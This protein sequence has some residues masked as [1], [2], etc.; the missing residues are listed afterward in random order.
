MR[1]LLRSKLAAYTPATLTP[2]AVRDWPDERLRTACGATVNRQLNLL[3][4]VIEHARKEWGIGSGNP[5]SNVKRPK[6]NRAR[7]R[8]LHQGEEG[9]LLATCES[10]SSLYLQ[11][12]VVIAIETGMRQS[13]IMSLHW[14]L[15]DLERATARL[16]ATKNG[17]ARTVPLSRAAVFVLRGRTPPGKA[18][19]SV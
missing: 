7:D 12:V 1:P 18:V 4:H 11:D 5:V 9:L 6:N 2:Q 15:V 17:E 19:G 14:E 8:R 10:G 13:E 3:H 16:L